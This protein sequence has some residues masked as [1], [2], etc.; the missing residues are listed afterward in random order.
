MKDKK[1][2]SKKEDEREKS[3]SGEDNR[4]KVWDVNGEG[5]SLGLETRV[6][7]PL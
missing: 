4:K 5:S 7:S 1:K 3:R 6:T 2:E